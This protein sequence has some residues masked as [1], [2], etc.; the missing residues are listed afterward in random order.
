ML[1]SV[2]Y[3]ATNVRGKDLIGETICEKYGLITIFG[4]VESST[5]VASVILAIFDLVY[6]RTFGPSVVLGGNRFT[7]RISLTRHLL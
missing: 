5:F 2:L 7:K 4:L 3:I 6:S 1:T